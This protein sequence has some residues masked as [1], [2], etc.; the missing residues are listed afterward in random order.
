MAIG[1]N[2][3]DF[4]LR[5]LARRAVRYTLVG[6]AQNGAFYLM[7]LLL[8]H[9]GWRAWQ[10]MTLLYPVS[11]TISFLVNRAWSFGGRSFGKG[12]FARYVLVYCLAYPISVVLTWFQ[13]RFGV[14]SW[15][16]TLIT[17]AVL[18]AELFLVLNFWVFR[19]RPGTVEVTR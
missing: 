12:Q 17:M 3:S 13:E 14:P 16:A 15:L 9:I 11:V 6:V 18:V 5:L 8:L 2:L 7:T 19:I 1:E 4:R 10:A